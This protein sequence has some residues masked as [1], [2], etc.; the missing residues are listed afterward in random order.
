M[1]DRWFERWGNA[2]VFFCKL[3]YLAVLAAFSGTNPMTIFPEPLLSISKAMPYTWIFESI[4]TF[5]DTN[6][7]NYPALANAA[8]ISICYF[9]LSLL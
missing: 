3:Y 2:T 5:V 9:I 4:R 8:V 7:I 6:Q 1:A